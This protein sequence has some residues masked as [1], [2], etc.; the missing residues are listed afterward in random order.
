MNNR[1]SRGGDSDGETPPPSPGWQHRGWTRRPPPALETHVT[2]TGETGGGHRRP[3][4]PLPGH[5]RGLTA[6]S[7]HLPGGHRA[8]TPAPR[9]RG[10]CHPAGGG[11]TGG[12][13]SPTGVVAYGGPPRNYRSAGGNTDTSRS[14]RALP[15]GS[16]PLP[17][18]PPGGEGGEGGGRGTP[19]ALPETENTPGCS[20]A[21]P[22]GHGKSPPASLRHL[23]PGS[24][25]SIAGSPATH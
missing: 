24:P 11:H 1:V 10:P 9:P 21:S 14:P 20:G 22:E 19:Q 15:G 7:R 2:F 18:H 4:A 17:G 5:L 16:R 25:P 3:F 23:A 13:R 12:P 6:A 8:P